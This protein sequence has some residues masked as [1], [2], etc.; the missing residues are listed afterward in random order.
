MVISVAA[1]KTFNKMQHPSVIKILNKLGIKEIFLNLIKS[2]FEK[3][4]AKLDNEK[5][6][7]LL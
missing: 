7:T 6:D 4:T 3:P 2:I 5:L 1:E